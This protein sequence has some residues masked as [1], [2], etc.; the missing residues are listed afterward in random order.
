[1]VI[2]CTMGYM[3]LRLINQLAKYKIWPVVGAS[4]HI[5]LVVHHLGIATGTTRAG[6]PM[7]PGRPGRITVA[8]LDPGCP[9]S[10]LKK[11]IVFYEYHEKSPR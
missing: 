3:S 9:S 4:C 1:M 2:I 10:L 6:V 11:I 8:R 5:G 7:G